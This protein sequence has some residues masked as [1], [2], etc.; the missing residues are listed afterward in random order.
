MYV[1]ELELRQHLRRLLSLTFALWQEKSYRT[2][3][4]DRQLDFCKMQTP[5]SRNNMLWKKQVFSKIQ[6]FSFTYYNLDAT[7]WVTW[8]TNLFRLY[9]SWWQCN[10]ACF[11]ILWGKT[12]YHRMQSKSWLIMSQSFSNRKVPFCSRV[13][14]S[15]PQHSAATTHA[16]SQFQ[17]IL[18]RTLKKCN[19]ISIIV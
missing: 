1:H 10:R 11:G 4:L 13:S 18:C 16:D 7:H 3:K 5:H 6:Y 19:I 17:C 12:A 15:C 14:F 2:D 8:V 9:Q